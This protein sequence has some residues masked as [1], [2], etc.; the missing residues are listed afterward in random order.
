MPRWGR[1]QRWLAE[2]LIPE[3]AD[4]ARL[5]NVVL[6]ATETVDEILA[7]YGRTTACYDEL[8]DLR[9]ILKQ[10]CPNG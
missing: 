2:P 8:L 6:S 4:D 5:A 10:G 9:N 7:R 3:V 1:V